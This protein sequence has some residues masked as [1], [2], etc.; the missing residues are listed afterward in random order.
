MTQE[1]SLDKA[2]SVTDDERTKLRNALGQLNWLARISR[3]EI[4]FDICEGSTEVKN[5]T[6]SDLLGIKKL[7]KC[8]KEEKMHIKFPKL[9]TTCVLSLY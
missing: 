5:V 1:R 7:I 2:A 9:K 3:P 4:S 6:V 8:V